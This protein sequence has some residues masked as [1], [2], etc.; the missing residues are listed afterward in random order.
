MAEMHKTPLLSVV[1]SVYNGAEQISTTIDSILNQTFSDFEF[2]IVDDGSDDGT[3]HVLQHYKKS[4]SRIKTF[5][6]SNKGITEALISG[7]MHAE[8]HYIARQDVGDNSINTRLE[9]QISLLESNPKY[10]IVSTFANIYSK[11]RDFLYTANIEESQ[12]QTALTSSNHNS[13]FGPAHHGSVMFRKSD[14]DLA[15]GYR[16]QFYFAQ[17]LDLWSRLITK[18]SHGVIE[19]PLYHGFLYPE[20][21]T[22]INA[23]AQRELKQ[24]IAQMNKRRVDGESELDLLDAAEKIRPEPVSG[25]QYQTKLAAGNY[26]IGSCLADSNPVRSRAY[27]R[28]ALRH[29]NL[30]IN[31]I[32]KYFK[33]FLWF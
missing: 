27:F 22:G 26:F 9:D 29:N 8:G 33:T 15:G 30:H 2:L 20:S 7:C 11:E 12:L 5:T 1:M 4:D 10:N 31:A 14:Y 18:G 19:R 24:I 23:G 6:Q 17:D 16:K 21:L 28:E 32:V 25:S 3:E 13:L